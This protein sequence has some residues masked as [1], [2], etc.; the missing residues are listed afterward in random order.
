MDLAP[1]KDCNTFGLNK[2]YLLFDRV[3]LN[4]TYHVSVNSLVIQQSAREFEEIL[5]CPSFLAMRASHGVVRS[6]KHIY[7]I[8]TDAPF[9][10]QTDASQVLCEGYTVTYVAMQLAFYMGFSKVF[11]IGVDHNFVVQ[12]KPNEQ[13]LLQGDDP[14]HFAPNYFGNKDWN[15]PDLEGSEIA[16]RLAKFYFERDNRMICDATV[17]GKLT[18]FPKISYKEALETCSQ[19]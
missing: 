7:R 14:N 19:K 16:Y 1:L 4:L 8:C 5:T 6:M 10:F 2:I 18:I 15:L 17:G 12:G 9:S 3:A 13:Q 11:L